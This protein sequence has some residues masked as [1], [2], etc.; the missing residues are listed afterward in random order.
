MKLRGAIFD[1]DGTLVD[2]L[3]F[4]D[5]LWR[6][7]GQTYMNDPDFKPDAIV[8][9]KIRT[10]IYSEAMEYFKDYYRIPGE[11][12]DFIDFANAGIKEFYASVAKPKEGAV[13]LLSFL[14]QS[15][16]PMCLAS[17]TAAEYIRFALEHYG[18]LEYFDRV[19][20]CADIGI[21]KEK[22]DIYLK[23]SELLGLLPQDLCV[24]ED[25]SRALQTAKQAGFMTVGIYDSHNAEQERVVEFSDIYLSKTQTLKDLISVLHA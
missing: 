3:M 9:K 19:I 24:F 16:I 7:I 4:W 2:S 13:E 6:R 11:A 10:M 17:A 1:M 23:A 15:N 25:S 21:G 8:D 14:K 20:S 12:A 5:H 22:P 18:M